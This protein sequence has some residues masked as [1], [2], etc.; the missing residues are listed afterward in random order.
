MKIVVF[1]LTITSAWGNGHATTYRSLLRA[2]AR[3]GH[4]IDFV[5]KE[6]EWYRNNRDLPEPEFCNVLL[7][8]DWDQEGRALVRRCS[9]ADALVI[10]SYFPDA[11]KAAERLFSAGSRPVFF[12]DIDT[13][14]T[15]AQLRRRELCPYLDPAMIPQFSAYL[16]FT[17]GPL[18]RE[19]EQLFGAQYAAPLYCSVD[20]DSHRPVAPQQE[21]RSELSYL[22]TYAA[23]RQ[24]KLMRLLNATAEH[25][26]EA[27]FLVAGATYPE[28]TAWAR[29]VRQ[30]THISPPDH[31][32]FYCSSRF[33]L[34]LTRAEMIAVGYSPSVR[35]FEASACG[36]AILS[37]SWAGLQ[38]FLTPGEEV[39][40]TE[41]TQQ[42]IDVLKHT[43]EAERAQMGSRA[44]ERI[45][46]EHTSAHRA[47]E[48]ESIVSQCA[49]SRARP[50][51]ATHPEIE[52]TDLAHPSP[53]PQ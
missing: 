11:I 26:P 37:D 44:R 53:T 52:R 14:I 45:L 4:T 24:P 49:L 50:W 10:G 20:P 16:S 8:E 36:A 1:G 32:A 41:T 29:N 30:I 6:A 33:T 48:F 47:E 39:L 34:N 42:V 46:T 43:S 31:P 23:D 27:H 22:G 25:F 19:L 28:D 2:L 13:P 38:E 17:G 15:F 40:L 51:S 21:F 18:L 9:D 5:E 35:L 7:Y 12:Y 3:R